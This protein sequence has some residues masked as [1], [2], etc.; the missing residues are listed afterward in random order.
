MLLINIMFNQN[1]KYE[2]LY[3]S[4]LWMVLTNISNIDYSAKCF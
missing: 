4:L 2:N 1:N 3:L